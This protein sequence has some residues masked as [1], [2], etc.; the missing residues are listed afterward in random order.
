M[1]GIGV[2]ELAFVGY[3]VTNFA[4]ARTFYGDILG[5]KEALVFEQEGEVGWLEYDLAGQTLALT[6]ASDQWKPDPNGGGACL[7]VTDLDRALAH[8]RAND[9]AIVMD[10]QDYPACRLA[11]IADPDGNTL[12]LH[13]RKPNHPDYASGSGR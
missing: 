13:Q 9:V 3:P 11:L 10:I 8:L 2:K 7:E 6:R 1:K 5:L 4:K 12:A